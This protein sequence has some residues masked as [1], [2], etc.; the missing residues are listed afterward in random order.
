[1]E[2][3]KIFVCNCNNLLVFE[4]TVY[5]VFNSEDGRITSELADLRMFRRSFKRTLLQISF[6]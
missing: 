1:M 6:Q 5:F 4:L 2:L 3:G